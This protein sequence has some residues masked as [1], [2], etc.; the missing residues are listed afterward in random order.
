MKLDRILLDVSYKLL[1]FPDYYSSC[2]AVSALG[3]VQ[4]SSSVT[5]LHPA[6]V[7]SEPD[8]ESFFHYYSFSALAPALGL[9][10]NISPVAEGDVFLIH[11]E[12]MH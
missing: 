6:L 9:I 12:L 5:V 8:L 7:G 11:L 3:S 4:L 2:S 10:S 1:I